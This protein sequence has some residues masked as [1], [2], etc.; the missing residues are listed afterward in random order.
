M[1]ELQDS[2]RHRRDRNHHVTITPN[3]YCGRNRI[4]TYTVAASTQCSAIG[5]IRPFCLRWILTDHYILIIEFTHQQTSAESK[6]L[7]PLCRVTGS[8]GLAN[9]HITTL[10]TL[11][12]MRRE[13]DSNSWGF[14]TQ[15]VFKTASLTNRTLSIVWVV[16]FETTHPKRKRFYKPSRLS[17]FVALTVA[18]EE[19]FELSSCRLTG[20]CSTVELFIHCWPGEIRTHTP[21]VKS[22]VH[23]SSWATSHL[24]ATAGF[25][26][27]TITL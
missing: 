18:D 10:S 17:S 13:R 3:S 21:P 14:Y 2:S 23:L 15:S 25:E 11:Q 8:L 4:R 6:G 26:P 24:V 12:K 19:R 1:H 9:L 5:A 20:D 22:R 27:T 16:V 7:E